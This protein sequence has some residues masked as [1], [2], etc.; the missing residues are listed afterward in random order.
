MWGERRKVSLMSEPLISV[1]RGVLSGKAA[2]VFTDGFWWPGRGSAVM[3]ATEGAFQ[4][5]A[6]GRA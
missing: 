5:M 2:A 1:G 4:E 3:A 6:S